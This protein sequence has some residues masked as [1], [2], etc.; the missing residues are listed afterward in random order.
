MIAASIVQ[1]LST[2]QFLSNECAHLPVCTLSEGQIWFAE[3]E[4]AQIDA[5][6]PKWASSC[7]AFNF[8]DYAM[9]RLSLHVSH[10][11]ADCATKALLVLKYL[12]MPFLTS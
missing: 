12:E 11:S 9:V 3:E 6:D 8:E 5:P 7:R 10:R 4:V 1:E 2:S